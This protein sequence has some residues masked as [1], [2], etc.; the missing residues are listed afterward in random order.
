MNKRIREFA[1]QCWDQRLDGRYFDQE[2]FAEL[3]VKECVSIVDGMADPEV[4]SDRYIWAIEN[5][6]H[7]I[8][9]HFGVE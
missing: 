4:D 7:E 9:K 6:S 5:T 2:K 8:K 1:E 3:I